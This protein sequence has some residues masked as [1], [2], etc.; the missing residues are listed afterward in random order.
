MGQITQNIGGAR[1]FAQAHDRVRWI[2]GASAGCT[3]EA[4]SGRVE[5]CN[6]AANVSDSFQLDAQAKGCISTPQLLGAFHQRRCGRRLMQCCH[7]PLENSECL[8]MP[9]ESSSASRSY[10]TR[11]KTPRI[12]IQRRRSCIS[13][14]R[15]YAERVRRKA[16]SA[17]VRN[18]ARRAVVSA[19]G[20]VLCCASGV[21]GHSPCSSRQEH[22]CGEVSGMSY[23]PRGWEQ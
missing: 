15:R 3:T 9:P 5:C 14:C 2:T 22:R 1:D 19:C 20:V 12:V 17:A 4:F 7:S 10:S 16:R 6:N 18:G 11:G 8:R 21:C 13:T 23:W